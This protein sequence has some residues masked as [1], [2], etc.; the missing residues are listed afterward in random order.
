MKYFF[1]LGT[2]PTLSIA[3]IVSVFSYAKNFE[4]INKDILLLEAEK[5]IDGETIKTMGGTIK[6]GKILETSNRSK[7]LENIKKILEPQ[8]G[9]FHFGISFFGKGK[10]NTK[11]L[12]MEI[13]EHLRDQNISC[14]FVTSREKTL[15][16]VVVE[17]NKLLRNG[18]EIV[19]IEER[20]QILIGKTL[21]VQPFKELSH[22]DYGRPARD[23]LSGM[24]PP[25]LAQI[26]INLSQSKSNDVV[27]DPFCGSGTV[28][29]EAML[30]NYKNL[31]GSDISKK[32]TEDTKKNLAWIESKYSIT[33]QYKIYSQSATEL[34]KFLK[35]NSINTVITE[36]YLGP[37]RGKEDI[38]KI[39]KELEN[40]YSRTLA[41]FKKILK[42]GGRV[43]MIFP[44][45]FERE[46]L[47]LNLYG[48]KIINP[49]PEN[50]QNN[51][52]IR[53]TNRNTIIYGRKGQKVWRE[54]L[55]LKK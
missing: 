55:I 2:N 40:L 52:N 32:A 42:S 1:Q 12:G 27:L 28:L 34:S 44:V 11:K 5:E 16:S 31:I 17:Q 39:K 48:W 51:K 19:L 14:R 54:I 47:N 8:T 7:L 6:I 33:S 20:N 38:K 18:I 35:P 25:K 15:S 4:I 29:S 24:L 46:N 41:E 49:I 3:E 9:K 30:M 36:P 50:L 26:M 45:F 43:T 10:F 13:K 21:S 22:R 53:L 23:D 37:Q